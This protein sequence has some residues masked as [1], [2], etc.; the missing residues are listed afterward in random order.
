[1]P[2]S[3]SGK[4]YYTQ[5]QY[6]YARYRCSALEYAR[7]QG[8]EIESRG[9]Y[10]IWKEH[11]SLTFRPDGAMWFWNSR[12]MRGGAIEFLTHIEHKSIVEAV[13][14]LNGE[15]ALER[16]TVEYRAAVQA[17]NTR[18]DFQLPER[19]NAHRKA[20]A[21]LQQ[22]RCIDP[23]LI[24]MLM[25]EGKLYESLPY[26]NA[27]FVFSD[28]Q[29]K[30]VGAFNRSVNTESATQIK[31]MEKGSNRTDGYFAY[32][33]SENASLVCVGEACID[34]MSYTTL[35]IRSGNAD[36]SERYYFATGGTGCKNLLAFLQ[37]HPHVKTAYICT[38]NDRPG[39]SQ[40]KAIRDVCEGIGVHTKRIAPV[41]NDFN[42]DLK[43]EV[44]KESAAQ[45]EQEDH[46][47]LDR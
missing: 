40:A 17:P 9:S 23:G 46:D 41:L 47:L 6:D 42:D 20:Y 28:N 15:R 5:D 12:D 7:S 30:A 37:S 38:N 21:Y 33:G 43:A 44:K 26:H 35:Q 25:K 16:G 22:S 39:E 14:T 19:N 10:Y 8:Y 13:L 1:M 4:P 45:A 34:I 11:D 2:I 24:S 32:G 29:G 3:K 27:T 36:L 18:E 31:R